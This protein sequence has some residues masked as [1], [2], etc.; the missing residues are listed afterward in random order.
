MSG[1]LHDP[2]IEKTPAEVRD[3]LAAGE[4]Q[5]VDVREPYE[6]DAGRVDGARHVEL[7]RLA[8]SAGSIDKD[9][10]VVFACRG[11]VRSMMA[12]QAFKASGYDA[13][14]MN[15]GM[16]RWDAEGLPMVPDGAT[17]ADH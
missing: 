4:I 17:V 5:L 2:S 10:P 12:A 6:W 9:K 7:E 11:G 13:W 15:G 3:A 1:P 8:S 16:V 14:S